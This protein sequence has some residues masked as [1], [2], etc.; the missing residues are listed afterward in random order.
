MFTSFTVKNFRCFS[1]LTI[2]PLA[3]VNL[4]TGANNVGKTALLEAVF[5]HIVPGNPGISLH[6]LEARGLPLGGMKNLS[7]IF[8]TSILRL[9]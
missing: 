7:E 4:V 3:R 5:L 6:L 1:E 2:E 9:Q 8:A